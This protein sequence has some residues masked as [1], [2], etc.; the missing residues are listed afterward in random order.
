MNLIH[1]P[2]LV[3]NKKLIIKD[4]IY[5]YYNNKII[6]NIIIIYYLYNINI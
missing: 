4:F 3:F 2:L 6:I 5:L 1:R